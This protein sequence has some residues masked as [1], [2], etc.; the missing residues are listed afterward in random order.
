MVAFFW[1]PSRVELVLHFGTVDQAE[2][3]YFEDSLFLIESLGGKILCIREVSHWL[4][5]I[6]V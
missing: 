5:C 2:M 1:Q 6:V 3:K 4:F